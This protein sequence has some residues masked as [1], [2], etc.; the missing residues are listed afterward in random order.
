[1]GRRAYLGSF[2]RVNLVVGEWS[3]EAARE[4]AARVRD[5]RLVLL[6]SRVC[7]AFRVPF[8]PFA[9]FEVSWGRRALVLPHPSGR[10]RLWND[11]DNIAR[12]RAA[13]AEFVPEVGQLLGRCGG[14]R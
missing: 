8:R 13:V 6:G 1:M 3:T 5:S 12:A 9:A 11:P 4:A 10:C 7:G 14:G 2:R